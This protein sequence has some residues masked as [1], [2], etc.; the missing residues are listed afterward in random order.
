MPEAETSSGSSPTEL[1]HLPQLRKDLKEVRG[2]RSRLK[3][4]EAILDEDR[5]E[6]I[7]R[8]TPQRLSS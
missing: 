6:R 8:A 1:E 4:Q 2:L 3:E 5:Y 7:L